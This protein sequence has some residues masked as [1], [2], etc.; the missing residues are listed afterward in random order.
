MLEMDTH[1][2]GPNLFNFPGSTDAELDLSSGQPTVL[3]FLAQR[4]VKVKGRLIDTHGQGVS[5]VFV[6]CSIA[7]SEATPWRSETKEK[8]RFAVA[9]QW[10]NAGSAES[11]SNGNYEVDIAQG[12]AGLEI[13]REGYFSDPVISRRRKRCKNIM[14]LRSRNSRRVRQ[15]RRSRR[16]GRERGSIPMQRASRIFVV[17]LCY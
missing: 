5:N 7:A 11:D 16:C 2:L 6:S 8:D 17:S 4:K 13:I 10:T 15:E 12:K 14:N 3:K 9:R 1:I